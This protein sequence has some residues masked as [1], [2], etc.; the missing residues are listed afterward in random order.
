MPKLT[1]GTVFLKS[2]ALDNASQALK[3]LTVSWKLDT[4]G[5]ANDVSGVG[6]IHYGNVTFTIPSGQWNSAAGRYSGK[7]KLNLNYN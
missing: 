2:D 7:L 3:A 1:N 4:N 6:D 5:I